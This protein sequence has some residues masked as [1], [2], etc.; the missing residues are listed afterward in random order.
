MHY[1]IGMLFV[2]ACF[3]PLLSGC[4]SAAP[5]EANRFQ[6]EI[7]PWLKADAA[8]P[9]PGNAVLF[10]GSSSIRLWDTLH[11]DF[12][13]YDVIQRGFGGA[14][15]SDVLNYA[16]QIVTPYNP[17]AIVVFVGSND[18]KW[19][20]SVSRIFG[21]YKQFVKFVRAKQ[22][23][24]DAPTPI[25]YIGITPTESRWELWPKMR[26]L[27]QL[28]RDYAGQ[29]EELYYID[30]PSVFL[31][32]APVPGGPPASDLFRDDLLH[33]SP[34]GYALWTRI[35]TPELEA[36]YPPVKPVNKSE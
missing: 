11:E 9:P 6:C 19:G 25:I 20:K 18:I 1:V 2:I 33:L 5:L 35:I 21:E 31:A 8:E 27:N 14:H 16:D 7:D 29:H 22:Q 10:V 23:P 36:I 12:P 4:Q 30:T 28:I 24:G 32:S 15:F 17:G 13:Q 34:K 3:L 26:K